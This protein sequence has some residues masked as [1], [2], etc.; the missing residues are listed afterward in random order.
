MAKF[1]K[2][3][4]DFIS[5]IQN[6]M[7]DSYYTYLKPND[8]IPDIFKGRL[9]KR[10]IKAQLGYE[11]CL[12]SIIT[13]IQPER[14]IVKGLEEDGSDDLHT[15]VVYFDVQYGPSILNTT[16]SFQITLEGWDIRN[17]NCCCCKYA[18]IE[19]TIFYSGSS[20][21]GDF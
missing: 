18:V 5:K 11:G 15:P 17:K 4:K 3:V 7:S 9:I 2:Q 6:G 1:N 16:Y 21:N 10:K 14:I 20:Y 12:N 19:Y 13:N 8:T